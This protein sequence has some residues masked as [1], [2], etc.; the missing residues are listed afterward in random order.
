MAPTKADFLACV[1]FNLQLFFVIGRSPIVQARMQS[2]GVVKAVDGIGC[3]AYGLFV[4]LVGGVVDFFDLE[5][6]EEAF[7]GR[8]IVTVSFATHALKKPVLFQ[9]LSVRGAGEL[10][11][12]VTV[13][14]QPLR[15]FTQRDGLV[16]SCQ[17]EIGI[18]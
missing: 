17:R 16:E 15:R 12:P 4:R 7:H 11:S 13:N 2:D 14:D 3:G 9:S 10:R 8:V 1:V 18:A 5:T 6:F